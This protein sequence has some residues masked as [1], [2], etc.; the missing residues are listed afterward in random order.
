MNN[1]K[2]LA[3]NV[4]APTQP[5]SQKGK[6]LMNYVYKLCPNGMQLARRHNQISKN[7]GAFSGREISQSATLEKVC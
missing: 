5:L 3:C 7:L 6:G 2:A 1:L 4:L